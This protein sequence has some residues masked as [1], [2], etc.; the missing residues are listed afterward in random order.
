MKLDYAFPFGKQ[1]HTVEQTDRAPK[2]VFVL[3]VY[4]SAVTF[5]ELVVRTPF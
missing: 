1:V 3:G 5:S 4:A 2:K